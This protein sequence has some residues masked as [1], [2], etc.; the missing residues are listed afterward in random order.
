M[1]MMTRQSSFLLVGKASITPG[2][3]PISSLSV[4]PSICVN[5]ELMALM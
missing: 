2:I 4:Y 1:A 3:R 5:V